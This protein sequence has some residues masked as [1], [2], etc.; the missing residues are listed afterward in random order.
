MSIVQSTTLALPASATFDQ[1]VETGRQ[2]AS[3]KR[4]LG[5]MIGDWVN[6]GRE[7]F[8]EQIE[9]ALEAAGMDARFALKAAHVAKTF[10][11]HVRAESLS[12]DHHRVVMKLPRPEQLNLLK[13]ANERK[14]KTQELK[15]AAVQRRYEIG[16]DFEDEDLDS[17]LEVQMIRAWN[18]ATPAARESFV[19]RTAVVNF[20]IIDEDKIYDEQEG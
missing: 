2:L 11:R 8:A 20:G 5:F 15:D 12:F 9:L 19:E 14:W 6:H 7:H 18:R 13:Q 10:P 1:W 17:Y 4:D 3:M 16:Q